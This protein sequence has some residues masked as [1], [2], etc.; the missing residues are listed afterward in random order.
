MKIIIKKKY[1]NLYFFCIDVKVTS[2]KLYKQLEWMLHLWLC[3]KGVPALLA[4]GDILLVVTHVIWQNVNQ[5]RFVI[6]AW[7]TAR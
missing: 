6:A 2:D 1:K 7:R 4:V 5:Q 3:L